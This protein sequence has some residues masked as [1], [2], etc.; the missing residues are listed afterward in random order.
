MWGL[1]QTAAPA[2][3]PFTLAEA[4]DWVRVDQSF[5]ADDALIAGQLSAA[6]IHCENVLGRQFVTASWRLSLDCFPGG[7]AGWQGV[8]GPAYAGGMACVRLPKAPLLTVE[9]VKYLDLAGT[10]QTLDAA[11][12]DVDA[13]SDPGRLC[14]AQYQVWPVTR[15]APGAVR[16]SFTSGYGVAAA[17][18]ENVKTAMK[19]LV[20][21][22]YANRESVISGTIVGKIPD[23]VEMLLAG[24]WNGEYR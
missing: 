14:L 24:E 16:I 22:W 21:T 10:E 17:V 9:S 5:T 7:M 23:T 11:T 15:V 12:Y 3:E 1:V 20:G 2:T 13:A 4:K 8:F 18:P 19:L 6:R